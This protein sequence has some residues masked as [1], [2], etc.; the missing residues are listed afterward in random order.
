MAI[1][2]AEKVA[3]Q[4]LRDAGF[5]A[6]VTPP[7]DVTAP[8]IRVNRVGGIM[9]NLVTDAAML[10]VAAYAADPAEAANMA[11][12]AREALFAAR[13]TMVGD[14]WVRWWKEAAGPANLPDPTSKLTRYQFSGQ[15]MIATNLD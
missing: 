6:H 12:K 9:S 4:I 15:L 10:A 11:N 13:T 8:Y 3:L 2:S 1:R 5:R 14:A 7:R